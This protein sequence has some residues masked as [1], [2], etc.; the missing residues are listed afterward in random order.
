MASANAPRAIETAER[1]RRLVDAAVELAQQGGYDAVQMRD[2]ANRADVALATLYRQY[3]SK[4]QLLLA[5]LADQTGTLRDILGKR[6]ARG[7]TPLDRV[8]GVLER[9]TRALTREPRLAGAMVTA[10][11][12]PEPDAAAI[13]QEILE[14]LRGILGDAGGFAEVADADAALRTL[15]YVWFA[16]LGAWS[17]GMIDDDQMLT[18]LSEAARLLL[19]GTR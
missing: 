12:S 15:G 10:L 8:N 4:D 16:A 5:A 7:T 1:R 2:V 11:G 19:A 17:G 18:D 6:P 14:L 13:K 9:A 3:P